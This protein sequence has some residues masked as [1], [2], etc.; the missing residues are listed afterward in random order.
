M[1]TALILLS[2]AILTTLGIIPEN[3]LR[4]TQCNLA[5]TIDYPFDRGQFQL[6]QGFA[7]PSPRHQGRYHT[8]EDWFVTR[9]ATLGLP[10]R[11]IAAGRVT[12]S[13][14][15]GWGRDGG[16]VIIE[17][18]F[19]DGSIVYS[20][21]G[22]MVETDSI[23]FPT[24]L[25]CV[26]AGD[27][28]GAIGSARPAPHLHLEIK[29]NGPDTPGPGYSWAHPY[30]EGWRQP[31]KFILNRQGWLLPEHRWHLLTTDP[32]G[33]YA[34]PLILNDHSLMYIDGQTL[35]LATYDGRVLW[36]VLLDQPA[37]AVTAYQG[38]P[39]VIYA[40]GRMQLVDYEGTPVQTWRIPEVS[41]SGAPI[42]VGDE[43]LVRTTD[44]AL[45]LLDATRQNIRWRLEDVPSFIQAHVSP[46][47]IALLTRDHRVLL[48]SREGNLL[49]TS[50]LR[51]AASFATLPDGSLAVY[52]QGGL[53]QVDANGTWSLLHESA[54]AAGDSSAVLVLPDNRIVVYDGALLRAYTAN[55]GQAS[56]SMPLRLT[57]QITLTYEPTTGHLLL[58]SKQGEIAVADPNGSL[59]GT[60]RVYGHDTAHVWQQVSDD[61][62][63]RIGIGDQVIGLDYAT[64]T[65]ACAM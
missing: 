42:P 27:V 31:S 20:Q 21:Y 49:Q 14:P 8:G 1:R 19:A 65:R 15:L 59:C 51:G 64:F 32:G 54:A 23:K 13:F 61:G 38:Q 48:L 57:G 22:H 37:L 3:A 11:A 9:D 2:L 28:I 6:A 46:Q 35:R 25:S 41:L 33:F 44:H 52:S 60:M 36:R 16:V 26:N 56:W 18:T 10:V 24:R 12:Y 7:V 4:Q 29:L 43:L 45:V 39:L 53:W 34:A 50:E 5:E 58:L 63:W 62:I 30:D 55:S 40:D 47:F 17:H